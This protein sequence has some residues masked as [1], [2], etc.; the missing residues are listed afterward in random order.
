MKYILLLTCAIGV[1][2]ITL[3]EESVA[4]PDSPPMD[5]LYSCFY[6]GVFY[7]HIRGHNVSCPLPPP[8][9]TGDKIHRVGDPDCLE[10]RPVM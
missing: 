4:A 9:I 7:T 3:N 8:S 10:K 6:H 1:S 5:D 2:F